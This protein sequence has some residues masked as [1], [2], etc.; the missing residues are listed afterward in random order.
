M[1]EYMQ[2]LQ[3]VMGKAGW[4]GAPERIPLREAYGR[5]LAEDAR[6]R[7]DMP[8]FDKAAMDG[9]AVRA[10]DLAHVP[11][12]L[13]VVGE[14]AAGQS[15]ARTLEPGQAAQVM[16]G[17]PVPDGADAVVQV[18]WTN[19]F[20]RATVTV[21]RAVRRG[22][23]VSPRGELARAEATLV[24]A[25]TRIL[26]EEVA[27]LAA[28]GLDPCSV[29][30][31]L[32][33]AVLSTGDELVPP[34]ETPGPSQIR[35]S[36]GP[37]LVAFLRGV[38]AIPVDLG[39]VADDETSIASALERGLEHDSVIVT[40]GVS[41]GAYD[42]VRDVLPRLGVEVHFDKL[43]VKPG[44]PTVFGTRGR[45]MIFGLPGNPVSALVMARV[46]VQPAFEKRMG[47]AR[48]GPRRARAR[49]ACAID[50]K[51][52]RLWFV[53]GV[54]DTGEPLSVAPVESRGSADLPAAT[55]GN[56]LIVAPRGESRVEAGE[57]VDVLVWA[58]SVG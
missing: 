33:V 29:A 44:R 30:R 4:P 1:I 57:Q 54:L 32:T 55:R 15:C 19:G 18:E 6:A 43:A 37:A 23:H 2:A 47:L 41:A 5:I 12:T 46:L 22:E 9:F 17:A 14:V 36:N 34:D 21:E 16:T 25:G 8:P 13:E 52:D 56:C 20:D 39:R 10:A 38:G 28:A 3:I 27:L 58:R 7:E 53:H 45:K 50:K 11:V 51:P 35:N 40:G 42:F 48:P 31:A 24:A 26:E 49:L